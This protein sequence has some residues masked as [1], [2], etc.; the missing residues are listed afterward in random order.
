MITK[1]FHTIVRRFTHV[2][3]FESFLITIYINGVTRFIIVISSFGRNSCCCSESTRYTLIYFAHF[4]ILK[5]RWLAYR[6]FSKNNFSVFYIINI[7]IGFQK[8]YAIKFLRPGIDARPP[9]PPTNSSVTRINTYCFVGAN[10]SPDHVIY[11]ARNNTVRF[12][13]ARHM[14]GP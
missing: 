5:P 14:D 2:D 6:V 3:Y 4:P 8:F 12:L 10:G 11:T 1:I 9:S 13:F 7:I